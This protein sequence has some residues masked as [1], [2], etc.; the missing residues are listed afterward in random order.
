MPL[1]AA[2][3]VLEEDASLHIPPLSFNSSY[4]AWI[5]EK[6][7]L[8][9]FLMCSGVSLLT[10]ASG[11]YTLALRWY[12]LLMAFMS[13]EDDGSMPSSVKGSVV[14]GKGGGMAPLASMSGATAIGGGVR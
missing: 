13:P 11:W 6:S 7:A 9:L 12:A 5:S 14:C 3:L 1:A 2:A 8:T 4:A 10:D